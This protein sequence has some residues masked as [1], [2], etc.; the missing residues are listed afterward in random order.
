MLS[1]GRLANGFCLTRPTEYQ[2]R[3]GEVAALLLDAWP[4]ARN[5]LSGSCSSRQMAWSTNT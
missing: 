3:I 4:K 5:T 1:L 2:W